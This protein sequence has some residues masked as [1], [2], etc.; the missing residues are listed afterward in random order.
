MDCFSACF[1]N[2]IRHFDVAISPAVKKRLEIFNNG[3]QSCS[4]FEAEERIAEAYG[5]SLDKF[6]SEWIWARNKN[7]SVNW[8]DQLLKCG[9]EI[10]LRNGPIEQRQL[11]I[12]SLNRG[13]VCICEINEVGKHSDTSLC[14]HDILVVRYGNGV[15]EAH[16]PR[17]RGTKEII[18]SEMITYVNNPNGINLEINGDYFFS[19]D[20]GVMK[21]DTNKYQQDHGYKFLIVSRVVKEQ[22]RILKY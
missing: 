22:L 20:V 18:R 14:K 9:I 13:K 6:M 19:R 5:K 16:D 4:I 21:P 12:D 8:A 10:E 17:V 15:L 2:A 1:Q 3:I 11:F 7:E